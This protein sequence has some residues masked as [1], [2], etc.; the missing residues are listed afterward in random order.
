[1]RNRVT[2]DETKSVRAR[3][4]RRT[5]STDPA[6]SAARSRR[7]HAS[8]LLAIGCMTALLATACSGNTTTSS[9]GTNAATDDPNATLLVWVDA[10][11]EAGAKL[12]QTQH[13]N[14][15]MKIEVYDAASLLTKIQLFNR[16]GSGWPDLVFTGAAQIA[17]LASPQWDYALPLDSYLSSDVVSGFG[18]ALALNCKINGK[19]YC[20]QNDV[21]QNLLWYNNTLMQQFG[22]SVP[23]TW[24]EY[25]QLGLRVAREHPGYVVGAAGLFFAYDTYFVPSGCPLQQIKNDTEVHIDVKDSR[26]TRVASL[27]DPLIAAGAI[28]RFGEFDPEFDAIATSDHVLM[29]PE[30]SWWGD[31]IIKSVFKTPA[32]QWA[33]AASP[34]WSDGDA[35]TGAVGGGLFVVSKHSKNKKG[36]ADIATWLT[37]NVDYQKTSV[38]YPAFGPANAAWGQR[39]ATDTYYATNPYPIMLQE[40]GKINPIAGNTRYEVQDAFTATVVAAIKA[41]K[42]VASALPDLGTQLTNLAQIA[43]YAVT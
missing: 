6:A 33:A 32:G 11:R 20:L 43:G 36:A 7:G 13:P 18:S 19:T 23:T 26:C 31:A 22:Y 5:T 21:A 14:V 16:T 40:A 15:K 39:V 17:A 2:R 10:G 35:F 1:M 3:P 9:G 4:V 29:M 37:T 12:Y 42:S 30:A 27:M 34:K 38:T 28:S 24:D 25:K 8:W 41:G